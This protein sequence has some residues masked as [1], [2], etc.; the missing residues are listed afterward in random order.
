MDS[1]KETL[2]ILENTNYNGIAWGITCILF[3]LSIYHLIIFF[4]A[5][6]RYFLFYS[7]Y[8]FVNALNI[9]KYLKNVFFEENLEAN[10]TFFN[11]L[12]F[13]LQFASYVFFALFILEILKFKIKYPK[14]YKSVYQFVYGLTFVFLLLVISRYT[15]DGYMLL[16]GFYFYV[17]MPICFLIT[18]YSIFL[19]I[20][21]DDRVKHYILLGMLIISFGAISVALLTINRGIEAINKY[22]YIFYLSLLVENLLFTYALSIKQREVFTEKMS[23]QKKYLNQLLEN[24]IIKTQQNTFLEAE[25]A[26]KENELKTISKKAEEERVAKLKSDF[27]NEIQILHLASLQ[28]Q[29]NPHFIFN[30]LNSIK[31]FLI[32]NNK[33]KAVYYLNKFSKLIRKILES[34]RIESHSLEEELDIISL[35]L[36]IENIRFEDEINYVIEKSPHLSLSTLKVPPLLLQPFVEN[37]IW[38]GLMLSPNKKKITIKVYG[39]EGVLKI[40]LIDNG[41]GRKASRQ[42]KQKKSF[43]K[44]SV[45]LKMTEER[46][47]FFN[48]KHGFDYSFKFID[49]EDETPNSKGTEVVFTFKNNPA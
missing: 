5:R 28:S 48:Q 1:F 21:I 27:N 4:K 30:A 14:F 7:L 40:S 16:R 34:S 25:L 6:E 43:K 33:E 44:D 9:L 22:Y 12:H 23:L 49:L 46:L 15:F 37:A 20:K 10:I 45:G 13:P 38:H 18:V 3:Y 41:I 36:S 17:F 11:H 42:L 29:M 39:E 32:E 47:S 8:A 35:Y 31:V 2:F 26:K 19:I 24:E